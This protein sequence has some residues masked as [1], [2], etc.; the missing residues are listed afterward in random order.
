MKGCGSSV[1]PVE[2]GLKDRI[3]GC[4][5]RDKVNQNQLKVKCQGHFKVKNLKLLIIT[6]Y[7]MT[8]SCEVFIRVKI[9]S[10]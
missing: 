8:P 6:N 7:S 2:M 1:V 3:I 10:R 4:G 9:I 5:Q